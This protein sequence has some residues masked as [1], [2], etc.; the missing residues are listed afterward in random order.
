MTHDELLFI[1]NSEQY[2]NSRT[3][4]TPYFAL[5]AVI[6]LHKVDADKCKNC[7]LIHCYFCEERYPCPTIQAIEKELT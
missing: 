3:P 2:M 5:R 6:E 7:K 4:E 1:V